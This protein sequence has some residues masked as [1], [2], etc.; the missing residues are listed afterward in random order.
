MPQ[1]ALVTPLEIEVGKPEPRPEHEVIGR[2]VKAKTK[3]L[4]V[5]CGD[6]AL[7]HLLARERGAKVRGLDIDQARVN[8]CVSHGLSVVQGDADRDFADF[9]SASFD[10][11]ILSQTLQTLKRPSI[12]LRHAARIGEH[13][14]VSVVNAAHWKTRFALVSSGRLRAKGVP[15][16]ETV[17]HPCSVRD[18]VS[19]ARSLGLTLERGVPM[20]GG[21]AGA[22]FAKTLWRANWFAEAVVFQVAQG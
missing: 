19:L 9:P 2:L 22:P 11:V 16:N 18:F 15:W 14:I 17:Q 13:V 12:A 7:L 6:G 20:S 3:V 10:Y 8:A 1:L 5:G 4:D 21:R